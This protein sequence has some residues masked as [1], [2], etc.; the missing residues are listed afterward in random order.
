MG[1]CISFSLS[2]GKILHFYIREMAVGI[3]KASK[4]GE[5][6]FIRFCEKKLCDSVEK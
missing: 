4:G 2:G 1:K 3:A 6:N 5:V